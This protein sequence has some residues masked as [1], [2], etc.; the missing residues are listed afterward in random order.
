VTSGGAEASR[1]LSVTVR[2]AAGTIEGVVYFDRDH[3][4]MPSAGEGL[5]QLAV[6]F[7]PE[8]ATEDGDTVSTGPDGVY[9]VALAPGSYAV[10]F[11]SLPDSLRASTAPTIQVP[12]GDT[13]TLHLGLVVVQEIDDFILSVSTL[14]LDSASASS[15]QISQDGATIT[16]PTS[17]EGVSSLLSGD[18]LVAGVTEATPVGLLRKVESVSTAGGQTTLSTLR[19]TLEE[20]IFEGSFSVRQQLSPSD[21]VDFQ[22]P[23]GVT[24]VEGAPALE[25]FVKL[26]H[27]VFDADGN[28]DTKDDQ[29]RLDGEIRFVPT[30]IL[31]GDF[32][33]LR[34]RS[35]KAGMELD[36]DSDVELTWAHRAE[37]SLELRVARFSF[38]PV[39]FGPFLFFPSIDVLIG[40]EGGVEAS[41]RANL[42]YSASTVAAVELRDGAWNGISSWDDEV[43][44]GL[45]ASL[46]A[47]ASAYTRVPLRLDFYGLA[48]PYAGVRTYVQGIVDPSADPWWELFF[49]TT[50]QAGFEMGPFSWLW[51]GVDMELFD[52]RKLILDAGGPFNLPLVTI[53]SPEEGASFSQGE[54]IVFE[55]SAVTPGGVPL[56]GDALRWVSDRDG[57]LGTGRTLTRSDLSVGAHVITLEATDAFGAVGSASVEVRVT[58]PFLNLTGF[59]EGTWTSGRGGEGSVR[60]FMEHEGSTLS[61]EASLTGSPCFPLG[62]VSG[63]VDEGEIVFGV[64]SGEDQAQFSSS[65]FNSEHVTGTYTVPSGACAGDFGEFTVYKVDIPPVDLT[66]TWEGTARSVMGAVG[67]ARVILQHDGS[68]VSGEASISGSPCFS[69]GTVSGTVDP[70]KVVLNLVSGGDQARFLSV[71]FSSDHVS[72]TYSVP[73]GACAGD[74]GEFAFQKVEGPPSP[75]ERWTQVEGT[76]TGQNLYG[77][78]GSGS[79]IV[80]VGAAGTILRS[81][82]WGTTWSQA[83]SVTTDALDAVWGSGSSFVAVGGR[84][85]ILHSTDEGASWSRVTSG[86]NAILTGVWGSDSTIVVVGFGTILRSTDD[87]VSWSPA[88]SGVTSALLSVWG[89]GST[90]LAV[91]GSGAILRSTDGGTTWS[92]VASGTSASLHAVWGS[93]S[94]FVAVGW[95]GTILH[96]TDE[97]VSWSRVT[98]GT[99][100]TL[101]AV[102]GSGSSFVAVGWNGTILRS[103]DA[104][105]SWSPVTTGITNVLQGLWGSGSSFVAVGWNGTILR[106]TDEGVSWSPTASGS[107][108]TLEG[109]WGSGSTVMAVGAGGTIRRSTDGGAN[110]SPIASG[111]INS[112]GDVWGSGSTVV[113]VGASGTILRSTDEGVSWSPV[114]S[115]ATSS[116]LGVWGSGSTVVAVG[117]GGTILRSTDEGVSWSP[118]ASGTTKHLFSVWGSGSTVVAVGSTGTEVVGPPAV[119]LR[120]TDEGASWVPVSSGTDMELGG[121][122]GFGTTVVAVGGLGTIL[123]STD[124]GA[125]WSPITSGTTASLGGIWGSGSTIVAVGLAGTILRSTDAGVSWQPL[126]SGVDHT[127][128]DVWM[129]DESNAVVVGAGGVILRGQSGAP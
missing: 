33:R 102:W 67:T 69:S 30:V 117:V 121:V 115:G 21:L 109:V 77:A 96:S 113:A 88:A 34:L 106:S 45:N 128:G 11:P 59:W 41:L 73:Y 23:E 112:L 18:I 74:Y 26:E 39:F 38:A 62:S 85:T 4:G 49:G 52:L 118:I 72:G 94:S 103:T 60:V 55:G 63:T 54:P 10:A 27:V 97:G 124:E 3:D 1:G 116:L 114:Q 32:R 93:G 36:L 92:Q 126:K 99:T 5:A 53:A 70:I 17:T 2:R 100:N 86:T 46:N 82:D 101:H 42:E 104:G 90:I 64:L 7:L 125:S 40:V 6:A 20:A 58:D 87:G 66:G 8:D 65:D 9:S 89:S 57:E 120:S 51:S 108:N 111:T 37:K 61:G 105:A 12:L 35:A 16:V 47:S 83:V 19:A 14:V 48:G 22:A 24:L 119:I 79:T 110:W 50:G 80:A 68:M 81:T 71:D 123:R 13:V 129:P 44:G 31:E 76:I 28:H 43:F 25:F 29:I 15:I 56:T 127:F 78:S 122:W 75:V 91:G 107:I 95:G 84:G 98:S